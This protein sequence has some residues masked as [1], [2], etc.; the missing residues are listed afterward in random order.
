MIR[1]ALIPIAGNATRLMP[2]TSV[3]PKAMFPLVNGEN[4]IQCILHVI[5][6][7]AISAGI[8]HIGIVVS[9][10]QTDMV[11]QY[12]TVIRKCGFGELPAQIEYIIQAAP[13]G[14]GDAV[15]QG[16]DFVGEEPF[17]VLLGDHVYVH[18]NNEPPCTVQVAR[19]FDSFD[20]VAMIGTQSLSEKEL[21]RVGVVSG[22]QI[23]ENVYRCTRFIE[24]P[25]LATAQ[26][27]L[28]MNGLPKGTFLA[29][30]G[31]Y[32]FSPV[33]FDCLLHIRTTLQ[34][35][36]KE[37]ELANAQTSLL[38]KYP[39]KYFLCKISGQ[40]YDIGTP[41]GCADAQVAFRGTI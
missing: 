38:E 13:Q 4:Q 6:E 40:A 19:A 24:K 28:A 36:G 11:R 3:I 27:E 12:F 16:L 9:P 14:F 1:K 2:V 22:V 21:S 34:R 8:N 15:L 32:I 33:I 17:M 37:L 39:E 18:D 41:L 31:I 29:H 20:G 35:E 5:C 10:A 7:Q 23:K 25:D 30:C 26:R